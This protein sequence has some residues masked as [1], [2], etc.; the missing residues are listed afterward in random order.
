MVQGSTRAPTA[1]LGLM[2]LGALL[3]AL[4]NFF[5]RR[6]TASASWASVAAV[7]AMIGALVAVMVVRARGSSLV[8]KDGRAIIGRSVLGTL[9]MLLTFYALSSRTLSL[10]EFSVGHHVNALVTDQPQAGSGVGFREYSLVRKAKS[11]VCGRVGPTAGEHSADVGEGE[12][13]HA[14]LPHAAI[15]SG[16]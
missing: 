16:R 3:F 4:M 13:E 12:G 7:R 10:G 11:A 6:A 15:A 1:A 14:A 2:A 9:S 8:A 5:A